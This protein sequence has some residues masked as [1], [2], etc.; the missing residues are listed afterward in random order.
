MKNIIDYYENLD[1]SG[2]K[3]IEP[4]F[5]KE[6]RKRKKATMQ[7]NYTN[8][9]NYTDTLYKTDKAFDDSQTDRLNR[10]RH[11]EPDSAEFLA[12]LI[13][14]KNAQ[15]IL[16]IG[17]STGYS[18]LWLAYALRQINHNSQSNASL[19]SI[20]I[21]E[22]RLLTAR[23][24]LRTLQLDNHVTLQQVDAKDFL[25][26]ST[27]RFDVI[28]L[29]AERQFYN[30]YVTDFKRLMKFGDVLIVDNVVSHADE[31]VEFLVQFEDDDNYLCST[32]PIGAGLFLA[33]KQV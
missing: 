9:L 8:F 26:Q 14:S 24:H 15:N 27:E 21:D 6:L 16:E 11:L 17:T 13:I 7:I 4:N 32:L 29:D 5:I 12:S 19:T 33:V 18:T 3:E 25:S 28:F 23:N 30:D 31:V 22:W 1:M 20:D 10:H 2:F